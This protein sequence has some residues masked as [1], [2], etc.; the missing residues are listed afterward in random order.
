MTIKQKLQALA[1]EKNTPCVTISFN[2][3]RTYPDNTQDRIR[4]KNLVKER[5]E[6]IKKEFDEVAV[7]PLLEKLSHIESEVDENCNLD[8]LHIYLSNDTKEIIKSP[9]PTHKD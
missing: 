4:L 9:W 8:S 5:T 2:T 3:H 7:A 1:T 6:R